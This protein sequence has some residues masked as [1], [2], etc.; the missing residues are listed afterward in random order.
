MRKT[1]LAVGLVGALTIPAGVALAAASD[2]A[3][4]VQTE[5]TVRTQT[6]N[7]IQDPATCGNCAQAELGQAARLQERQQIHDP[8]TC[9]GTG[10]LG[11]GIGARAG[12]G[13]GAGQGAMDGT[14]PLHDGG[15]SQVRAGGR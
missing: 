5:A 9:D 1:I 13:A 12:G 2:D 7:Q 6:R 8:E 3:A 4:P 14:G 11:T 10:P 15:G